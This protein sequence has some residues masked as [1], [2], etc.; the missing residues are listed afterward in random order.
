MAKLQ[1]NLLAIKGSRSWGC[2]GEY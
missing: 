2:L 1:G